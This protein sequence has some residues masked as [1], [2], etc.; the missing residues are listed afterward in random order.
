MDHIKSQLLQRRAAIAKSGRHAHME[1]G[2]GDGK[3]SGLK[4][5]KLVTSGMIWRMLLNPSVLK[6]PYYGLEEEKGKTFFLPLS[7]GCY[8]NHIR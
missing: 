2:V 7:K 5:R 3:N 1:K 8:D 4:L 6:C